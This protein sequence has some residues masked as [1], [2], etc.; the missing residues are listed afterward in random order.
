MHR[1]ATYT[2]QRSEDRKAFDVVPV[3]E[4]AT[5]ATVNRDVSIAMKLL[6]WCEELLSCEKGFHKQDS[7]D[8][9]YPSICYLERVIM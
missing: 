7:I 8:N 4:I 3:E 2:T 1:I 5:V 9:E 6:R